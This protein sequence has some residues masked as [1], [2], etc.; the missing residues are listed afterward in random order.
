MSGVLLNVGTI[1]SSLGFNEV[2]K[3]SL[4]CG[5]VKSSGESVVASHHESD[6]CFVLGTS[7]NCSL[8]IA[9]F[10]IDCGE[11]PECVGP[12][13]EYV[14]EFDSPI[15]A[16][17]FDPSGKCLIASD[18]QGYLHFVAVGDPCSLIFSHKTPVSA[19]SKLMLLKFYPNISTPASPLL[20]GVRDNGV[21]YSV[22]LPVAAVL[23]MAFNQ[24]ESLSTAVGKLAFASAQLGLP[25]PKR[26]LVSLGV[27]EDASTC[28]NVF[29]LDAYSH[30]H[31]AQ[32]TVSGKTASVV[33]IAPLHGAATEVSMSSCVD[34]AL[35]G[36]GGG[37]SDSSMPMLV[38]LG[39]G[40]EVCCFGAESAKF[41]FCVSLD[42]GSATGDCGPRIVAGA[43]RAVPESGNVEAFCVSL[44]LQTAPS[45]SEATA[46]NSYAAI[47]DPN[48]G[49]ARLFLLH[50]GAPEPQT[51]GRIC[52][53]L[54]SYAGSS[55]SSNYL[56]SQ[57]GSASADESVTEFSVH[58]SSAKQ[59]LYLSALV[60]G[61]AAAA[62]PASIISE[63]LSGGGPSELHLAQ[64]VGVCSNVGV[65]GGCEGGVD[66]VMHH[67]EALAGS[68]AGAVET[69][70][71][72]FA[73]ILELLLNFSGLFDA[74]EDLARLIR[75]LKLS[76][77]GYSPVVDSM[78]SG[79]AV[80]PRLRL[81]YSMYCYDTALKVSVDPAVYIA[82]FRR[83][84]QT[85]PM[86]LW[87]EYVREGSFDA[88][89]VVRARHLHG[90][91][92]MA[93][94]LLQS[95]AVTADSRLLL[96]W[97]R[98]DVVPHFFRNFNA[99]GY[100]DAEMQSQLE[101]A[102]Q[103]LLRRAQLVE[104]AQKLPFEALQF[105]EL[106]GQLASL[107]A[108]PGVE[109]EEEENLSD[110]VGAIATLL[111]LSSFMRRNY[112]GVP[113]STTANRPDSTL[114]YSVYSLAELE[115]I[116][117]L[118]GL[119]FQLFDSAGGQYHD[120]CT[121]DSIASF[122]LSAF[123]QRLC[124]EFAASYNDMCLQWIDDTVSNR[125]LALNDFG[126]SVTDLDSS[127]QSRISDATADGGGTPVALLHLMA[128]T[129]S[130]AD[131]FLKA[132]AML[133]L[134]QVPAG[135]TAAAITARLYGIAEELLGVLG[136]TSLGDSLQEAVRGYKLAS[137][138]SRYHI[139]KL[140][141][142]DNRQVKAAAYVIAARWQ[143]QYTDSTDASAPAEVHDLSIQDAVA[144]VTSR[145]AG[146]IELCTVLARGV[147]L[148]VLDFP[149]SFS[150]PREFV[151]ANAL[152]QL[153]AHCL[154]VVVEN[155][156]NHLVQEMDTHVAWL[157][158]LEAGETYEGSGAR[159]EEIRLD[160][161]AACSGL[162][163]ALST[164]LDLSSLRP[165]GV[166]W[167]SME[168]LGLCKNLRALH[169]DSGLVVSLKQIQDEEHCRSIVC[170]V[171]IK[172]AGVLATGAAARDK[173]TPLQFLTTEQRRCCGILNVSCVYFLFELANGLIAKKEIVGYCGHYCSLYYC[174]VL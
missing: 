96:N 62:A 12:V 125:V 172:Q 56:R 87:E 109:G 2:H 138:T 163:T 123:L 137:I 14:L 141:L 113:G 40:G 11:K 112:A 28:V 6:S 77:A 48:V 72:S 39:N 116:G 22:N 81:G 151:V 161:L 83:M 46:I 170:G 146:G 27:S 15:D 42:L 98:S 82:C 154:K 152:K 160:W 105:C 95:V 147:L 68:C 145:N 120:D 79:A 119:V 92:F 144:F 139:T 44:A 67:L 63:H 158:E 64:L 111:E 23:K 110:Q 88:A 73:V 150:V 130:I 126:S 118:R 174:S 165:T 3:F 97:V 159:A 37:V 107:V 74:S 167:C 114:K 32:V 45:V 157:A 24:P 38:L 53:P 89:A 136:G 169:A 104:A 4:E 69:V 153:P 41:L 10:D 122:E 76:V 131:P 5:E 26:A 101:L 8:C 168:L 21:Y 84:V 100:Q 140:N 35:L 91:G 164:Y 29:I 36:P 70:A 166:S 143:Q 142:R 108:S 171:A 71:G 13:S 94:S 127:Y 9:S 106:A 54:G 50:S 133:L 47:V 19:G 129:C 99:R 90:V 103:D 124:S 17:C 173:A 1:T 102:V 34:V 115:D 49:A 66:L 148:R 30:A 149:A 7:N 58:R 65:L 16:L 132:K 43:V 75:Q 57:C 80:D 52:I 60:V 93:G 51:H 86:Y 155:V 59:A 33:F 134:L 18:N 55:A 121:A 78:S 20:V 25:Y 61:F 31:H 128:V 117:G 156:C 85:S 162:I 135:A